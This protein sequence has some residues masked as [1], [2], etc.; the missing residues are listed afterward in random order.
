[1]QLSTLAKESFPTAQFQS[2]VVIDEWNNWHATAGSAIHRKRDQRVLP[3]GDEAAF[4][5]KITWREW[6]D[7]R[8]PDQ[9]AAK[10]TPA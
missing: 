9:Q 10:V 1:M 2:K 5:P 6:A 8:P 7:S 4:N 3:K